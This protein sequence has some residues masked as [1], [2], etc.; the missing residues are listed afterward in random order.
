VGLFAIADGVDT[1][2]ALARLALAGFLT[3]ACLFRKPHAEIADAQT[4]F[5]DRTTLTIRQ[6]TVPLAIAGSHI[7]TSLLAADPPEMS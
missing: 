7:E 5:A 3:L 6:G 2:N 1:E 4:F